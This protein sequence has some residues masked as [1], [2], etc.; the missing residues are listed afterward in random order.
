MLHPN[1]NVT[2]PKITNEDYL[3]THSQSEIHND[4]LRRL[5]TMLLKFD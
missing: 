1:T 2:N 4:S 3:P 5:T